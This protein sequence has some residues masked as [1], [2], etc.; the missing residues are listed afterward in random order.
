MRI[1]ILLLG[2]FSTKVFAEIKVIWLKHQVAGIEINGTKIVGGYYLKMIKMIEA[3]MPQYQYE[4]YSFP[5][6]RNWRLIKR[7]QQNIVYCYYGA[8]KNKD[9]MI[10]GYYSQPTSVTLPYPI[11]S[12][13]G[14]FDPLSQSGYVSLKQVF[15][16][17]AKTVLF[18]LNEN[19]FTRTIETFSQQYREQVLFMSSGTDSIES[20]TV[21]LIKAG[22][23]DFGKVSEGYRETMNIAKKYEIELSQYDILES[24]GKG[25]FENRIM[26][27]KTQSGF[28]IIT[29]IDLA[30]KE[31][32][33][34]SEKG[35]SFRNLV[36]EQK[37]YK[38]HKR[39]EFNLLW[40]NKFSKYHSSLINENTLSID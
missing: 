36:F 40:R 18:D 22:R 23:I 20:R 7:Q 21:R 6:K 4:Y 12:K 10:W 30:L 14:K 26:C 11:A 16:T 19:I 27:S 25:K 1:F 38:E 8:A 24:K 15:R 32:T 29:R 5:M 3:L 34:D 28:S 17:G 9:R 13:K 2:L 33:S 31:L 37:G 39:D 35:N